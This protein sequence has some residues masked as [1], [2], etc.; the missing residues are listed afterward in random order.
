LAPPVPV[1]Q[2]VPAGHGVLW[3]A[4]PDGRDDGGRRAG[5]RGLPASP[6]DDWIVLVRPV[7]RPGE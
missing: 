7:P 1:Y 3:S 4:G 5:A 6:G 2:F